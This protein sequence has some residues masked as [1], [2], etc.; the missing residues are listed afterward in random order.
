LLFH[1][2]IIYSSVGFIY[3]DSKSYKEK[4]L[5]FPSQIL[6]GADI[7]AQTSTHNFNS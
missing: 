7:T 3:Y 1:V 2:L 4:S 5:D 6:R